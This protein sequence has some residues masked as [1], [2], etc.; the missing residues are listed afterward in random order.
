[1]EPFSFKLPQCF[2][3]GSPLAAAT[4]AQDPTRQ[5]QHVLDTER[6]MKV[7]HPGPSA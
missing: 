1:M 5:Q 6:S 2:F 3:F 4:S 7:G